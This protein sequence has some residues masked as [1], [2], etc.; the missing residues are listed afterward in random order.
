MAS[1]ISFGVGAGLNYA[2]KKVGF[3]TDPY[4][5]F[6]FQVEVDGIIVGGFTEIS[7]LSMTTNVE[8]LDVGG[9]NNGVITHIKSTTYSDLILSRG[10]SDA[11]MFYGWYMEVVSGKAIRKNMTIFLLDNYGA[12]ITWWDISNAIPIGWDGPAL[13]ASG[14]G[15][16]VATEKITIAYEKFERPG[17]ARV[18]SGARTIAGGVAGLF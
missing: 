6:N 1:I 11:D 5:P 16:T 17:L 2:K 3:R 12:P 7:G 9:Q 13:S 14:T 18:L 4:T 15:T 10:M 8:K